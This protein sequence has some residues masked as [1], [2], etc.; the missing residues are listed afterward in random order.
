M[1]VVTISRQFGADGDEI[2]LKMSELLGYDLVDNALIVMVAERA[3]VSFEEV[4]HMDEKYQSRA[5]GF[6]KSFIEPRMGKI[7]AGGE[8]HID[9]KQFVEYAKTVIRGLAGHGNVII[10]GRGGQFILKDV[11]NAFHIKIIADEKFRSEKIMAR[12]GISNNDALERVRKSDNMRMHFIERYLKA[13]WN[14]PRCYHIVIDSARLGID[15]TAE[16]LANAVKQYSDTHEYIPGER[17]RRGR[18]RRE[19]DRRKG[20]RRVTEVGW[21][22]REIKGTAIREGRPVRS[23]SKPERRKSERRQG[24]RRD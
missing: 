6:L 7:L 4:E 11:E 13:D 23:F 9:P 18:D 1:A 12:D 5:V 20:D 15:T 21:T 14:D 8:H 24:S 19:E 3:G 10:V 17:D 2:A 22:S 16:I